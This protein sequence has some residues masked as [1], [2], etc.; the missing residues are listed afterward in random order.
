VLTV[1]VPWRYRCEPTPGKKG[2]SS[3]HERLQG[4]RYCATRLHKDRPSSDLAGHGQAIRKRHSIPAFRYRWAAGRKLSC[5]ARFNELT[6][7]LRNH[8]PAPGYWTA[9]I[10]PAAHLRHAGQ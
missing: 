5:S 3:L 2:E 9:H 4:T 7:A 6:D 1:S 8:V 10:R